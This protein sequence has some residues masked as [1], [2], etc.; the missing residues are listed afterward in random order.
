MT[1]TPRTDDKAFNVYI[2]FGGRKKL[3]ESDLVEAEVA[4]E[5][6]RE[7][8]LVKQQLQDAVKNMEAVP[9]AHLYNLHNNSRTISDG[10]E[11]V[12]TRLIQAVKGE[13]P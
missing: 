9:L 12:R 8:N 3:I 10:V 1:E 11:S 13:Q 4:R 6:E 2:E 7:L 5:L